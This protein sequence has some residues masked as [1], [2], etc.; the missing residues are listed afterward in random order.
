MLSGFGSPFPSC[1]GNKKQASLAVLLHAFFRGLCSACSPVS[2]TLYAQNGSCRTAQQI[3][4]VFSRNVYCAPCNAC[5]TV[6]WRCADVPTDE[7]SKIL[8]VFFILWGCKFGAKKKHLCE[9]PDRVTDRKVFGFG[10]GCFLQ[11]T[12]NR[13]PSSVG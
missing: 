10:F 4:A 11:I 5:S 13:R 2:C 8:Y 1:I 6:I 3:D 7:H 12:E 9:V